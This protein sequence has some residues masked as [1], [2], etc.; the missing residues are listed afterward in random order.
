ML[1][2]DTQE[3]IQSVTTAPVIPPVTGSLQDLTP[4][5]SSVSTAQQIAFVDRRLE[6]VNAL[7]DALPEARV[8]FI[9]SDQSGVTYIAEVLSRYSPEDLESVHIFTHGQAGQLQIGNETLDADSLTGY[10]DKLATWGQSMTGDILLYGCDVAEGEL[11]LSFIEQLAAV[12]GGDVQ[13]SD[14]LTGSTALGG[15]WDLEV[16]MGRIESALAISEFGQQ[17]YEG[18]LSTRT[19]ISNGGG[20]TATIFVDSG[21]REVTDIESTSDNRFEE[22]K[23]VFY[24]F[25]GGED[26]SLFR[27]NR[28]TGELR[29]R[30][31]PNFEQ[32]MDADGDNVY[33][34]NVSVTDRDDAS[35]TQALS[36]VVQDADGGA[37]GG[38]GG[39]APVV[40]SGGGGSSFFRNIAEG[41]SFVIDM[42]VTDADGDTE[43]NGISYQ[44]DG[45]EDA[46]LFTINNDGG[47]F[48][49][50]RPDFENP[51]DSNGDN[52]YQLNVSAT[53]ST[54]LSDSQFLEF[55][56]RN[57]AGDDPIDVSVVEGESVIATLPDTD[58][59]GRA[60]ERY[61]FTGPDADLFEVE[62]REL[63]FKDDPEFDDP[64]D[65]GG[66]NV[67]NFTLSAINSKN[68]AITQVVTV[69]VEEAPDELRI[70]SNEGG[71][72][73]TVL[74][75]ENTTFVTD[76]NAIGGDDSE[77]DGFVYSLNAG[78]DKALF[79]I[80]P[81]TG[82]I[83]FKRAP[84]FENPE[85][86]DSNNVY[87][88]NVLLLDS[89]GQADSQFLVIRVENVAEAGSAP[90]ITNGGDTGNVL[91]QVVEG[92]TL[93]ID[94]DATDA[95]GD[96]EG[97]GITYR[98]NAGED[99]DRFSI[100]AD[101]GE[102][103]F[104]VA[105][106]FENS[107][108]DDGDNIYRINVLA[109]DSTG[110]VDSQFVQI[111]VTNKVS[112]YL[113]GGQSNMA[114]VGSDAADLTGA[115]ANPFP[116]VQIWQDGVSNFVDL[117]AG[118]NSNFGSGGGFG[119][120]I[121]FGFALEAARQNG[122]A[123]TEEIYL[124][125]YALGSTDLAEDWD[126]NGTN[127]TY[128]A[129]NNWVGNALADL[130][131]SGIN[132]E[133]EAMLWAQG[134]N[135]AFN[136]T[137]AAN[138]ETNLTD[139]IADIRLRYGQG[140][141]FLIG[142]LHDELPNGFTEDDVVRS[143]Q[144]AV[145]NADPQNYLI[146]T[147]DFQVSDDSVHYMSEGHLALGEAFADIF[148]S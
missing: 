142:R 42:K 118:F 38:A 25:D 45:G 105:P 107:G 70:I 8:Y 3:N 55:R 28:Y 137:Q 11:G 145:A 140:I 96:T 51:G 112:V 61:E 6:D 130:T 146:D 139:F 125:K 92:S 89:D 59:T 122:T 94:I 128:A 53:D 22:L 16:T 21:T 47:I 90:V 116:N 58:P 102:I 85:D 1:L 141:D 124:V 32:P 71:D 144:I 23:G 72:N 111:E 93:A 84:D 91:E 101:T 37:G 97:N 20:P 24:S 121:G 41:T 68:I 35:D 79:D 123:D 4:F 75:D 100:E 115:H 12:T 19:I 66:D 31:V 62:N 86:E 110:L 52:L 120:E 88:V 29:F 40:T 33:E 117:R 9:E 2:P 10:T 56:V 95:D 34:V 131:S 78:N 14:D 133:V 64:E 136:A 36:I 148:I 134:E 138:Y 44:I 109:T 39:S 48:F 143:A 76:V 129:F 103:F 46:G 13:A 43:G 30:A 15:D 5:D 50:E 77:G 127:N 82:V 26:I 69:T 54:G 63:K 87:L 49:N 108:D 126:I 99:A 7:V 27:L 67:Y 73:A 60:I 81:E 132:Y 106:D 83:S 74:V 114:G 57:R 147:D 135:D 80:D 18:I 98:I 104:E 65:V 113:L 17:A 119:A